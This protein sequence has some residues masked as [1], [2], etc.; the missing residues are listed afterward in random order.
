MT[1]FHFIS[2]LQL[3]KQN[4]D[5]LQEMMTRAKE[6]TYQSREGVLTTDQ[7]MRRKAGGTKA[8]QISDDAVKISNSSQRRKYT[9]AG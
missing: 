3:Q 6:N 7:A 9:P 5:E 1:L 2:F 4:T 8:K